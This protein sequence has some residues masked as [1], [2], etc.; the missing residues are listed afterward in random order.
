MLRVISMLPSKTPIPNRLFRS[1]LS[2]TRHEPPSQ[3]IARSVLTRRTL[4]IAADPVTAM[5]RSQLSIRPLRTEM[6]LKPGNV[7][8]SKAVPVPWP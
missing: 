8:T 6:L 3:S 2:V 5:P 7:S 4:V 1:T